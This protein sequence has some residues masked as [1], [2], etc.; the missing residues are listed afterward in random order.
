M[1]HSGQRYSLLRSKE[2]HDLEKTTDVVDGRITNSE[3]VSLQGGRCSIHRGLASR[4][5]FRINW[6]VLCQS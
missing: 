6:H 5:Y 1:R 4:D 2:A 3:A